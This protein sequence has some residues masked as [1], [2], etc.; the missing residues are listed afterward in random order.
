MR[1]AGERRP[2]TLL[3][4]QVFFAPLWLNGAHSATYSDQWDGYAANRDRVLAGLAGPAVRNPVVLSGDVHSFW[5]NDLD[6]A[7]GR[8]IGG[9]IVTSALGASS[10][11]AGR[12][13]DV[14]ANNGHIRHSDVDHAGYVL[15]DIAKGG[16]AADL[17]VI[18]DRTAATSPVTSSRRFHMEASTRRLVDA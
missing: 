16:L 6:A 7:G 5:V 17:R 2:W 3:T 14:R 8:P 15:L 4:Q 18:A 1:L 11:P 13:G 9:E 12:F 10:P